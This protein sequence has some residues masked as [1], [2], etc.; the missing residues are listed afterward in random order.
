MSTAV[1]PLILCAFMVFTGTKWPL[2]SYKGRV[3][4]HVVHPCV[5]S[6]VCDDY[7]TCYCLTVT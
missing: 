2:L 7:F 1:P 4:V 6:S 5:I 3:A